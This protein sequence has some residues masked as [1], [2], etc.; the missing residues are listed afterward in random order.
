MPNLST[1]HL[2]SALANADVSQSAQGCCPGTSDAHAK[3]A[4]AL[5]RHHVAT[6]CT[7]G[8]R[9]EYAPAEEVE[10]DADKDKVR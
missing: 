4:R 8:G 7:R 2:Q 3:L 10:D 5:I 1:H 9:C 6:I